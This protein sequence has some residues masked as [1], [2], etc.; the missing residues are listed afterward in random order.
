MR[1]IG[2]EKSFLAKHPVRVP[3]PPLYERGIL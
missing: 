2:F 3:L 1:I